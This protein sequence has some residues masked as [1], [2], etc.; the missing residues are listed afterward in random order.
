MAQYLL[1]AQEF[2]GGGP[3]PQAP[4]VAAAGTFTK[5]TTDMTLQ[6]CLCWNI[7]IHL[8]LELDFESAAF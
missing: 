6:Y 2:P 3:V 4:G 8:F 5:D 7:Y 1:P